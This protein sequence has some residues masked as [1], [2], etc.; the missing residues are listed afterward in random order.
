MKLAILI[1][2]RINKIVH[3]KVL[4]LMILVELKIMIFKN[5]VFKTFLKILVMNKNKI[6]WKFQLII[7]KNK[8]LKRF[9]RLILI[10]NQ[11]IN[12]V[13]LLKFLKINLNKFIH[14]LKF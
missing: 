5:K 2:I 1:L 14:K 7:N 13:N 11:L 4:F 3:K 6:V 8:V 9:L 12:F 10:K